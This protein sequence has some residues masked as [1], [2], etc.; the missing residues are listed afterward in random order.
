M[1]EIVE[2]TTTTEKAETSEQWAFET[3]AEV[4]KTNSSN[5]LDRVYISLDHV[6]EPR[7]LYTLTRYFG[8]YAQD[9][10]TTKKH[11]DPEN[12]F[13]LTVPRLGNLL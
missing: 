6:E 2:C 3:W 7:D 13:G 5:L 8:D 9:A 1:L 10:L 12:V 11:Y 4:K